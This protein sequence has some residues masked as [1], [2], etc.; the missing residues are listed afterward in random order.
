MPE[1]EDLY[2]ILNL[3]PSA[4]P[5]VIEAAYQRLALLYYPGTDPS[6]EASGLMAAISRAYA[7]L[8]DPEKRAAYDLQ[9]RHPL[10]ATVLRDPKKRTVY[11]LITSL[12]KRMVILSD[13]EKRA[14]Y[15]Q[16]R[17]A[18]G[19][20]PAAQTEGESA[21]GDSPDARPRRKKKQSNADYF[22][23]GSRKAEVSQIQGPPDSTDFDER[24]DE[25][26][27][28][29]SDGLVAFNRSG[30]VIWWSVFNDRD[31][32]FLKVM[33]VPGPN[34]T[35]SEFFSVGSHKDDVARLQGTPFRISLP[36]RWRLTR[37]EID[38]NK[39]TAKFNRE[40]GIK[41]EGDIYTSS[42]DDND[43]ET[44]HFPGS[45]VEF[46][47]ATGRV[48]AWDNKDGSLKS[49]GISPETQAVKDLGRTTH[50]TPTAPKAQGCSGVLLILG[51]FTAAA[52]AAMFLA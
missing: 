31:P 39:E 26:T 5:G 11:D 43:D 27:W 17:E 24:S 14:T 7:V 19:N 44:W 8:G 45:T 36:F 2:E 40:F 13:P 15:D 1:T 25:E 23:I 16:N 4:H 34:A 35:T 21:E 6:P 51:L 22:T 46:S 18:G 52:I 42:G 48:T 41:H 49:Q 9:R 10:L 32:N 50:T 28:S 3:H 38:S 30:R 29:Y 33:M 20:A 47:I 12:R 37:D